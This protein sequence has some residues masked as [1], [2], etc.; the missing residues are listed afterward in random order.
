M[1]AFDHPV[2][3]QSLNEIVSRLPLKPHKTIKVAAKGI[4][5]A[6]K[7]FLFFRRDANWLVGANGF[8]LSDRGEDRFLEFDGDFDFCF[9]HPD[10][11]TS[12]GGSFLT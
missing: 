6:L 11:I 12:G 7:N 3:P 9:L 5:P 4:H 8:T 1:G 2:S 10:I